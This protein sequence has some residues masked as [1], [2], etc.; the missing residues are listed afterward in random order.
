MQQIDIRSVLIVDNYELMTVFMQALHD[1]ELMLHDKTALWPDIADSYMRHI[2]TM[3]EECEGVCLI[4]YVDGMPV[5]FIF[6][7]LEEQ[8]DSRI[9]INVGKELYVSDGYVAPQFRRMGLYR[10]LND[11]LEA[12]YLATGVKRILRFTLENNINM[13]RF[14]EGQGYKVSRVLYEKWV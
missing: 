14:L 3:Q 7:Y 2:I 11:V 9:E 6:G 5:G 4:A 8:D 10:R 12:H 1:N 13:R